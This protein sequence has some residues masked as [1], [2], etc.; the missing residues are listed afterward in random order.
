MREGQDELAIAYEIPAS[1][2]RRKPE[3]SRALLQA[4][5]YLEGEFLDSGF[6]RND[7]LRSHPNL[8]WIFLGVEVKFPD[9]IYLIAV[10]ERGRL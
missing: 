2:F 5:L 4:S 3:S 6:R 10:T 7:G 8:K 9:V 1:S